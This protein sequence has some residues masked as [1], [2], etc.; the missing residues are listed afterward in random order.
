[1]LAA[2]GTPTNFV[3]IGVL[4]R[5]KIRPFSFSRF[6][7]ILHLLILSSYNVAN[8]NYSMPREDRRRLPGRCWQSGGSQE[9]YQSGC[10]IRPKKQY[11]RMKLW[12]Q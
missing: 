10:E 12:C 3:E 8:I 7:Y 4:A 5:D 9:N 2:A 6:R 11:N 1:M